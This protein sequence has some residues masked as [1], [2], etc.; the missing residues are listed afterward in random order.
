MSLTPPFN[1]TRVTGATEVLV[2]SGRCALIGI[3]PENTT[4]GTVTIRDDSHIAGGTTPVRTS[5]IGL[6]Q[7]GTYFC[8]FGFRMNSGITIALSAGSDAVTVVWAPY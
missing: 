4:T 5:A 8:D 7:Q 6:T 3:F 1:Q 2:A